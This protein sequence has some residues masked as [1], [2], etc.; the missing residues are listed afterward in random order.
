MSLLMDALKKA[1]LAKRQGAAEGGGDGNQDADDFGGLALEPLPTASS[2]PPQEAGQGADRVEPTMSLASHLE[3]LDAQFLE[4]AAAAAR[5]V[6]P[7][8]I[9][10]AKI[11]PV[12]PPPPA[13]MPVE[14]IARALPTAIPTPPESPRRPAPEIDD[15]QVKAA[16]QNL[17]AAKQPDKRENRKSFAVA[18]GVLT[19]LSVT[20]IGGYFWWQLQPKSSMLAKPM[21]APFPATPP[22][23]PV[24]AAVPPAPTLPT[25][26][27][28]ASG[29]VAGAATTS[30]P[31]SAAVPADDD[32]EPVA[33]PQARQRRN[34]VRN[35]E[36]VDEESPVRVTRQPLRID[37]AL[38]RGFDAFNRGELSLAQIEY[39]RARKN[40]PRNTDV[41]HGLAAIAMRL[42]R[43]DQA[44]ALYRQIIESDPQ[45][46]VAISAL[47][48]QRGQ[49]DPGMTESRLKSLAAAQ[50]ELAAPHFSLGNLY[51]RMG[52]WNDAQQSYF[53]AFN[54]EPDNPD[55]LYNLAISLEHLRQNK[56]AAQYYTQAVAA[57]ASRPASFDRDQVAARLKSLQP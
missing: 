30:A 53:R 31:R 57:A 41:L 35:V 33:K 46:S 44:E 39:E 21:P 16:A 50:P 2:L 4:E 28:T 40:D 7:Q 55:I 18:I 38:T 15:T 36:L 32:D 56:L 43:H 10:T 12:A 3:E 45:D 9:A 29:S 5:Q 52:R 34:P 48:N 1:E 54:A 25:P 37:P 11:E 42:G 49:M 51:A 27:A 23:S 17:F 14:P 26:A 47:L 13:P 6:P 19:V 8:S 24:L 22:A 20:G